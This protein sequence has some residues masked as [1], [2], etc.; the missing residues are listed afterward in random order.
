MRFTPI[1]Q[2]SPVQP[3]AYAPPPGSARTVLVA[4]ASGRLGREVAR[5]LKRRGHRVRALS[6]DPARLASLAGEIDSRLR[7]D[8]T[9]P[10][11]LVG[12]CAGADVI[13][14]CVGASLQPGD[15]DPLPRFT[16]VDLRGTGSLLRVAREAEVSRFVCV[17]P[18]APDRLRETEYGA[19]REEM[20]SLV[21]DSGLPYTVVRPTLMF[22]LCAA[23]VPLA[24]HGR[25]WLL[26]DSHARINPI[27]ERD[28]AELC[29]GA[30]TSEVEDIEAGGP[31]TF[32]MRELATE[33][34]DAIGSSIPVTNIPPWLC[35]ALAASMRPFKPRAASLLA[36]AE[37]AASADAVAPPLGHRR[38][39][40]YL[41][42]A[43]GAL[44]TRVAQGSG[45]GGVTDWRTGSRVR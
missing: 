30:V 42:E 29:V 34:M 8:L 19:A 44:G 18:F 45:L 24:L 12:G 14:S 27:D 20:V 4:G 32:T 35:H 11:T 15:P 17:A 26:G 3:F 22:G 31:E 38:F 43:L 13:I 33:L 37:A 5:E 1:T 28:V 36:L 6:R 9:Q 10:E 25:R 23:V 41:R 40:D 2:R 21:A 7:G 16:D 39:A